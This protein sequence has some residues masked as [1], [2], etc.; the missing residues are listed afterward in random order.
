MDDTLSTKAYAEQVGVSQRTVQRWI[1]QGLIFAVKNDGAYRVP[2]DEQPPSFYRQQ[3]LTNSEVQPVPAIASPD[4][5]GFPVEEPP[6]RFRPEP[7]DFFDEDEEGD[8]DEE[9][10]SNPDEFDRAD[11]R[12]IFSSRAQ[13][14]SYAS[15]IP[16]ASEIFRRCEDKFYQVVVI[17]SD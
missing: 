12:R 17:P 14:E 7:A 10:C 8:E 4:D 6:T 11:L 2:F 15:E 9:P 16:I 13:A 3:D 1:Q 5:A